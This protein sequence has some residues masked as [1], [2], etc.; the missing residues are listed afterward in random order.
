MDGQ[1]SP[2]EYHGV[3]SVRS[4][5]ALIFGTDLP[6]TAQISA[7]TPPSPALSSSTA[8]PADFIFK[9]AKVIAVDADFSIA[10]AIA[11]AGERIVAVARMRQWRRT[12]HRPPTLL[13]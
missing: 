9:N 3:V 1:R 7:S 8:Q 6:A 5:A 4:S 13:I 10:Q 12:P 11:I 2:S